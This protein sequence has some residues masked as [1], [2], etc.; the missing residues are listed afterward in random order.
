MNRNL[1]RAV[2]IGL[3]ATGVIA[4]LA[5]LKGSNGKKIFYS[6]VLGGLGFLL[7]TTILGVSG[8]VTKEETTTNTNDNK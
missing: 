3:P 7:A 2:L 8:T 6:V 5:L 1:A 4:P